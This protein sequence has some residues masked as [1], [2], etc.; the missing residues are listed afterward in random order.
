MRVRPVVGPAA[1]L[2]VQLSCGQGSANHHLGRDSS[3]RR[4]C[5]LELSAARPN[6]L[7]RVAHSLFIKR[8]RDRA[9]AAAARRKV[10]AKQKLETPLQ[11]GVLIEIFRLFTVQ[12]RHFA[13]E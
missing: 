10:P 1:W 9:Q 8:A 3:P 6:G 13:G 4:S 5:L 12:L 2:G 7:A 11:A